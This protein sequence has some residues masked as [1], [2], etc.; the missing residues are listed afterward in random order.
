MEEEWFVPLEPL[1]VLDIPPTPIFGRCQRAPIAP[2]HQKKQEKE[3]GNLVDLSPYYRM[4]QADAA[5]ILGLSIS[6]LSKRWH[7]ASRGRVWPYRGLLLNDAQLKVAR[8]QSEIEKLK[9][10]RKKLLRPVK[11]DVCVIASTRK[12]QRHDDNDDDSWV[13]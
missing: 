10:E 11:A 6:T 12:R 9:R 4:K 13:Q 1:F 3:E 7:T 2:V 5:A 8:E